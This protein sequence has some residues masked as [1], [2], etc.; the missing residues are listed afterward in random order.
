VI[1]AQCRYLGKP[2]LPEINP[3][4][5]IAECIEKAK[6]TTD[7]ELISGYIAEALGVLQIDNNED[8][9]FRVLGSAFVDAVADD[10]E[11]SGSLFEV[12]AEL[13][14]RSVCYPQKMRKIEMSARKRSPS[15][16]IQ[17]GRL[18]SRVHDKSGRHP[19]LWN[20]RPIRI[21]GA[22]WPN[23]FLLLSPEGSARRLRACA[24]QR[25]VPGRDVVEG[26]GH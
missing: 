3:L 12:W 24:P 5:V 9:A 2:V 14:Q 18:A 17:G 10:E 13:V 21:G 6:A 1:E 7:P 23:P 19:D 20:V 22:R 16:R 26:Q 11:H 8:D 4:A 15:R 25:A